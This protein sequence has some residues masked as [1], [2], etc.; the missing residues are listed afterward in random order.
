M[1][2]L[3]IEIRLFYQKLVRSY[4][5]DCI[6]GLSSKLSAVAKSLEKL[7][8]LIH[9]SMNRGNDISSSEDEF[10]LE[11]L[12]EEITAIHRELETAN[13]SSDEENEEV[14]GVRIRKIRIINSEGGSDN[15][16]FAEDVPLFDSSEWINCPESEEIPQR[17]KH[18]LEIQPQRPVLKTTAQMK[19]CTIFYQELGTIG[20]S[21]LNEVHL[22]TEIKQRTIVIL[23][24]ISRACI[25]AIVT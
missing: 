24:P 18:V 4:E 10:D 3:Q 19:S 23:V 5:P 17:I 8:F 11:L 21:A 22:A 1:I 13:A 7:K 15:D 20:K 9:S 16:S 14:R 6:F 12:N 25:L 2:F